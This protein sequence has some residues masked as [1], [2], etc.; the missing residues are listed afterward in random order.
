[1]FFKHTFATFD[2]LGFIGGMTSMSELCGMTI[3]AD[4]RGHRFVH[5]ADLLVWL[6]AMGAR[7]VWMSSRKMQAG[8]IG[9]IGDQGRVPVAQLIWFIAR[10]LSI[11]GGHA[12]I[13][14]AL[15]EHLSVTWSDALGRH[16]SEAAPTTSL[17]DNLDMPET[18]K[19]AARTEDK[20]VIM[21]NQY[22]KRNLSWGA[23]EVQ[24]LK[25]VAY[26]GSFTH[27]RDSCKET[28]VASYFVAARE[29]HDMATRKTNTDRS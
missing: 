19:K 12:D 11:E 8:L 22:L 25:D 21:M 4:G 13:V 7:G 6:D 14:S 20:R 26:A 3:H 15:V 24:L 5:G 17:P 27:F 29:L 1:M 2:I 9:D 16:V 23:G 10:C 18:V 28:L